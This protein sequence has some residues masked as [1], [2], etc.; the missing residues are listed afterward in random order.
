MIAG[1]NLRRTLDGT[2]AALVR[3]VDGRRSGGIA[4]AATVDT[5]TTSRRGTHT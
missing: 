5:V 3:L 2:R 1:P 4:D